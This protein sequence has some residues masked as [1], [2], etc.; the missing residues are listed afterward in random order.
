MIK[1]YSNSKT[2]VFLNGEFVKVNDSAVS[3]FSQSLH[4]GYAVFEGIRAYKT[5]SPN[6]EVQ[7]F[8]GKEHFNRLLDSAK[9]LHLNIKYSAEELLEISYQLLAENNLQGAYIRPLIYAGDEMSLTPSSDPNIAICTWRWAKYFDEQ[10][11][12]L[13]ISSYVKPDFQLPQVSGKIT[14]QYVTAVLATKEA[15]SQGYD[16][17]LLCDVNGNIAQAPGANFFYE[18]NGQLFT[19]P[20]TYIF[21]GITRRTIIAL[22]K[23]LGY[24][25]II[26]NIIPKDIKDIDGAFLTGTA[27]EV[28]LISSIDGIEVKKSI[29]DSIGKMLAE[30]YKKFVI[31]GDSE[32]VI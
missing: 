12:R 1:K 24:E 10:P 11:L 32:T 8:K 4:Y 3:L 7:I 27:T 21:S 15:K 2:I 22:A 25:V 17:A 23:E 29:D 26:K 18:K 20:T 30:R 16:E 19:P 31:Q 9:Q 28:T 5:N 14:G 13:Q 6:D